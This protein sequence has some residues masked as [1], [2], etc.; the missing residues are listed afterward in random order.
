[1]GCG[2]ALQ[3]LVKSANLDIDEVDQQRRSPLHVAAAHGHQ[4]VVSWLVNQMSADVS[5]LDINGISPLMDAIHH[6]HLSVVKFLQRK[7]AS[8]AHE[9]ARNGG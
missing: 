6:R 5:C 1:M 7:G 3:M 8:L 2:L 9:T 4:P